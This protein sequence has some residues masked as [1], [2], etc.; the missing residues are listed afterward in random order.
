MLSCA[1]KFTFDL[2]V[3]YLS[4]LYLTSIKIFGKGVKII[5]GK[6]LLAIFK[7]FGNVLRPI[8]H[9]EILSICIEHMKQEKISQQNRSE[10]RF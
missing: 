5:C 4:Y 7:M 6:D 9:A 2:P 8:L 3:L 10:T 1:C